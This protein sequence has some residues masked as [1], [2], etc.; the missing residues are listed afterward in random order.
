MLRAHRILPLFTFT[1]SSSIILFGERSLV[2]RFRS[3]LIFDPLDVA[4]S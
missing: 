4:S 2:E 1:D 3:H